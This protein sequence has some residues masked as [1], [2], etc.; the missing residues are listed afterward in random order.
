MSNA[1]WNLT[2]TGYTWHSFNG[3]TAV[4]RKNIKAAD[5]HHVSESAAQS[6]FEQNHHVGVRKCVACT[7]KADAAPAT[8]DVV[9][10]AEITQAG[11]ELFVPASTKPVAA[12]TAR[13]RK[14]TRREAAFILRERRRVN[15]E[16]R[17]I[18]KGPATA[19]TFLRAAG[20]RPKA[21]ADMAD[22]VKK[23]VVRAGHQGVK[24]DGF[25]KG[26]KTEMTR[27]T[28]VQIQAGADKWAPRKDHT[29]AAKAA[30]LALRLAA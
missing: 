28:L 8:E 7:K 11:T 6:N 9:T 14:A 19:A 4:C 21:A 15:R 10:E 27:Y 13:D 18:A 16:L 30:L 3:D 24:A 1:T 26:R 20:V 12:P 25:R 22:T 23:N 2:K 17:R 29:K 5:L